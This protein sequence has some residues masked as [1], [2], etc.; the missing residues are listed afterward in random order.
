ML[1]HVA[2]LIGPDWHAPCTQHLCSS[3][4][5]LH[6]IGSPQTPGTVSSDVSW[7]RGNHVMPV[8]PAAE[9]GGGRGATKGVQALCQWHPQ[10]R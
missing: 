8:M 10:G 9:G 3:V 7:Q 1:L 6:L 5:A 4:D 2:V